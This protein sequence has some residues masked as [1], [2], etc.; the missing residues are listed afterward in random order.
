MVGE[1]VDRGRG[2]VS[3]EKAFHELIHP[4][5]ILLGAFGKAAS[6]AADRR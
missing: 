6:Q 2:C 3:F 5:L 1:I 4:R